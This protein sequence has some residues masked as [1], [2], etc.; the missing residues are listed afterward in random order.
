MKGSEK[1]AKEFKDFT[2][3]GKKLSDLNTKY[4]SVDFDG[5][6]DVNMAMDRDMEMGD[7]NRYKIEPNYFYDKWNDTLEF[8][9]DII[10]DPCRYTNQND[11]IITKS[12]RREITKWLTSSHFP[13]WLMFS[14]TGDTAD[15]AIRYFGWFN[16]IESFSVNSQIFGLKLHFKCTTPFGYTDNLITNVVCSTYKNVLIS[17][18]SD[19]LNSYVYPSVEI[20]PKT[21]GDIYICNMSDCTIRETGTLSSANTNYTSQLVSFVQLYAKS[22]GCTAEFVISEKTKDIAWHCNN[23]LAQFKLV[24]AYG[25]ETACT[26]F[27]RTDSK[28]YYIIENGIMFMSVSKNLKIYMD[29]QKLTI[30]DELGRMIRYEKL[31]IT[32][33]GHMYW[34]QLINGNNSLLF[35]GNCD[36]K[37]KH[38]E[39]R[40]V[41]E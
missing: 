15:D 41:G 22:N 30:N 40:K 16:N 10:K 29:C 14:K 32:D 13:E 38:V 31:G 8:E 28:I 6:T 12:E 35:Y 17:N 34:L 18:N 37:V 24:D 36:F 7:S 11:A 9:L 5:G 26:V 25:N 20:T 33:V 23:T 39:S 3:M 21:T 27:Y 2:F 4:I 19:E 1:M